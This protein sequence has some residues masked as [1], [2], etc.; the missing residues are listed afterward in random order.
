MGVLRYKFEMS[1]VIN[2]A[3][4]VEMTLFSMILMSRSSAVGVP[5]SPE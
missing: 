2:L 1:V 5:T 3:S 4:G